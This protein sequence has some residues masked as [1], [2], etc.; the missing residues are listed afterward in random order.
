MIFNDSEFNRN[1]PTKRLNELGSFRR[2]KSKHRPRNDNKLFEKGTIP[3]LHSGDVRQAN[4]FINSHSTNYNELGLS[5]S[6][7]WSKGT[8]CITIAANIAET[9]ILSYDMCFPDSIVGFNAYE[10]ECSELFMH[11]IFTY[12]KSSIQARIKGS[13]QDN[14]NIEYLTSLKFKIPERH[15]RELI[16]KVL[17]DLDAKIEVNN[18][19]NAE[20][21][22]MAK[23][24]Y[25][26]WFVQFDFPTPAEYAQA[27]G[28]PEMEGKPYKSSGGKMVY[29]ERLKREIPEGWESGILDDIAKIVRGVTYNKQNIKTPNDD[30]VTPVLR[31]TNITGNII[32]L[33][34]MVY[35]PNEFVNKRQ[36][37]KKYNILITMSSG[38]KDHIGKNGMFYFNEKVAFGAFCAKLEA[39]ETFQFYLSSYMQSE[40]IS[41][42]IKKEC[43]GTS[44]NNL[45]GTM[46]KEFRLVKA[47]KS[48]LKKYNETLKPIHDKIGNNTKENQ[49][50]AALR[51]WLLPML[52]NGQ[53]KVE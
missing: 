40:F 20:L 49:K 10:E 16:T 29:D 41:E 27:V 21:E 18:K 42:T 39:K 13:I 44:I 43:L 38:S 51:D 48:V 52:M 19:I 53:V 12:I 25:D 7:L 47:D 22:A 5:Q 14:I 26:Y 45:N 36:I 4:L 28:R 35:V 17:Y 23:L 34:N 46:V 50:L 24:I 30:C 3:L 33:E 32:D 6:K 1:W 2:G 15:E 31:A 9:A 11:Y 8:L 37:L